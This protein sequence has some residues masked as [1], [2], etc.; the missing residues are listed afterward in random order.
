MVVTVAEEETVVVSVAVPTEI[1][2]EARAGRSL[3]AQPSQLRRDRMRFFEDHRGPLTEL[4]GVAFAAD[5]KPP[6]RDT[7]HLLDTGVELVAPRDVVGGA[8]RQDLD[9]G[10]SSEVLS[11]IPGMQFGAAVQCGAVA[12]DD[13][14]EFHCWSVPACPVVDGV[15]VVDVVD[16]VDVGDG[17]ATGSAAG[18]MVGAG[19]PP[20]LGV[21]VEGGV[22]VW[23]SIAVTAGGVGGAES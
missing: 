14:G 22:G 19:A 17:A 10:V 1:V 5:G 20:S 15:P 9:I 12:L 18:V 13:D 23:S 2:D 8:G 6:D 11:N 4:V 7:I 3:A 21:G 16:V